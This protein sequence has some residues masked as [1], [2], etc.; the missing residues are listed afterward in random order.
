MS[1]GF[2]AVPD[3]PAWRL[4]NARAPLC[5]LAGGLAA[6]REGFAAVDLTIADGRIASVVPAGTFSIDTDLPVLDAEAGLVLPRL[7][8]IHTHLD[9]GHIWPRRPN[10]DGTFPGALEAVAADRA[11]RWTAVD[12]RARMDFSLRCAFAHGTGA[13]RT[14]LDSIDAQTA[15][16]WPVFDEIR[17]AWAGRIALQGVSLFRLDMA[18][19]DEAQF[20]RVVETTA[21]YEGV[22]GAVT[23]LGEA[24]DG[25]TDAALDRLFA[26]A[27]ANGLDLDLHVDESLAPQARTLERVAEA[28]LRHRFPGRVLCGHCCALS[29]LADGDLARL[30]DKVAEAR[31]AVVA[32]PLCNTYLQDRAAGRTPRLRGIAPLHE[33]KAAGVPVM[34]AS[35][36]TRDPFYPHGD[37]DMLEV[38]REATRLLHLDHDGTEWARAVASTPADLMGLDRHGRIAAGEAADLILFLARTWTELFARPQADR[39]VLVGGRPIDTTLP[40]HRELDHLMGRRP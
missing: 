40:D 29:T 27:A 18:I 14:H 24:P 23:F 36:N 28:A 34:V 38:F 5:L 30:T 33:L 7:V 10:P 20:R 22:L 21:R 3:A 4:V 19:D 6:D 39:T 12:V 2:A 16:T 8:D 25:R 35:D 9:K 1:L 26:A 13:I 11:S 37:L 32:L 15:I 17:R 31:L